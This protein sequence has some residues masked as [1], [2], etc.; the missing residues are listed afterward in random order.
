MTNGC[1][2]V[3][4]VDPSHEFERMIGAAEHAIRSKTGASTCQSAAVRSFAA[5]Q[6][7]LKGVS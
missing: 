3:A 5:A 1:E 4:G 2:K 6:R 7:A